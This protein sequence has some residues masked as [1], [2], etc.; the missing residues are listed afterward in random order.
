MLMYSLCVELQHVKT[1]SWLNPIK[2]VTTFLGCTIKGDPMPL[3]VHTNR[4][5]LVKHDRFILFPLLSVLRRCLVGFM[6]EYTNHEYSGMRGI[7]VLKLQPID[8]GCVWYYWYH[9]VFGIF[10]VT[11]SVVRMNRILCKG[12]VQIKFKSHQGSFF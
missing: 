12:S 11:Q 1:D 6:C 10:D 9:L 8:L 5:W 4:E 7:Q 3:N 2:L